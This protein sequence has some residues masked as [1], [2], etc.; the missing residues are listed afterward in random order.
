MTALSRLLVAWACLGAGCS[1]DEER[2]RPTPNVGDPVE[3]ITSCAELQSAELE[4][5]ELRVDGGLAACAADGLSCPL[6]EHRD[7]CLASAF[8]VATCFGNR[9]SWRCVELDS[10]AGDASAVEDAAGQ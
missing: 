4:A 6:L 9:W 3:N 7:A 10:G 2:A 5:H 8:P 1:S